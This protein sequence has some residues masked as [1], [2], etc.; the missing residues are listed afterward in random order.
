[1]RSSSAEPCLALWALLSPGLH[2]RP[3]IQPTGLWTVP[4]T[5]WAGLLAWALLPYRALQSHVPS[6]LPVYW[7]LL[8]LPSFPTMQDP[9]L[10]MQILSSASPSLCWHLNTF[11]TPTQPDANWGQPNTLCSYNWTAKHCWR[12][13]PQPWRLLFL[14]FP[15]SSAPLVLGLLPLTLLSKAFPDFSLL[16]S[17]PVCHPACLP[18][19]RKLCFLP[20]WENWS[21]QD[22]S[23]HLLILH[24]LQ[25]HLHPHPSLLSS[26]SISGSKVF[27]LRPTPLARPLT[28]SP[29][30]SRTLLCQMIL[31]SL[32]L[33]SFQS[34]SSQ[35]KKWSLS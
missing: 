21:H 33:F 32:I 26:P 15:I 10:S 11:T 27:C 17:S 6:I 35:S 23:L 19:G 34:S 12:E 24:H 2:P 14:Q 7:I 13:I 8:G 3:M 1:M 22:R 29:A 31:L 20:H 4:G 5:C 25:S 9:W 16:S 18:L 30:S 28:R